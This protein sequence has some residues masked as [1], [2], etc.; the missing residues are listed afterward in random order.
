MFIKKKILDQVSEYVR[1]ERPPGPRDHKGIK[2]IVCDVV[3]QARTSNQAENYILLAK[4]TLKL[5][6]DKGLIKPAD[7]TENGEAALDYFSDAGFVS[8]QGRR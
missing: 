2:D 6:C 7:L 5:A 8:G 3:K 4:L 1:F